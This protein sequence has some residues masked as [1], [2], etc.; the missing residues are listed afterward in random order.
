MPPKCNMEVDDVLKLCSWPNKWNLIYIRGLMGAFSAEQWRLFYKQ[1]YKNIVLVGTWSR[2]G[3]IEST[4]PLAR[5]HKGRLTALV[6]H[7]M[8][9][10]CPKTLILPNGFQCYFEPLKMPAR[11]SINWT[12]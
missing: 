8:M 2:R 11:R 1:A 7:L 3:R 5:N 12:Q 10:L 9:A 6:S 4:F